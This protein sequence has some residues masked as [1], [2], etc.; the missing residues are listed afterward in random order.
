[1]GNWLNSKLYILP[2]T[3]VT[4]IGLMSNKLPWGFYGHK[5]INR[6]AVFSLP[7]P[8]VDLSPEA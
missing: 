5:K 1:M 6:Q 4:T 8:T 3:V 7:P 2:I